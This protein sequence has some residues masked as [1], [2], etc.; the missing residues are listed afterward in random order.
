[1]QNDKKSNPPPAP[2]ATR[3]LR[4]D[5]PHLGPGKGPHIPPGKNTRD[6]RA[7]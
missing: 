2:T 6:S 7:P 1:M 5:A 3:K 4:F